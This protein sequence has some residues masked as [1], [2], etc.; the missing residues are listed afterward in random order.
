MEVVYLAVE[1]ALYIHVYAVQKFGGSTGVRDFGLL[2]SALARPAAGMVGYEAYPD[3]FMKAAVLAF[4]L[5]KNHPF[6][7]GNKRTAMLCMLRFLKKNQV[8]TIAQSHDFYELAQAIAGN[9]LD[10]QGVATWL[11]ERAG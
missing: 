8:N 11:K 9:Q 10:E 1:E 5:V 3:L 4:S 2:E 6:I 7:D